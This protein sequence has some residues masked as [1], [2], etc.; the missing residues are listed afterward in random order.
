M[1]SSPRR[2]VGVPTDQPLLPYD[3]RKQ[4]ECAR[5][6]NHVPQGT[7]GVG[8]KP[9]TDPIG[10]ETVLIQHSAITARPTRVSRREAADSALGTL[11]RDLG[12]SRDRRNRTARIQWAP[13]PP[14]VRVAGAQPR[15]PWGLRL[16]VAARRRAGGGFRMAARHQRWIRARTRRD[17]QPRDALRGRL[18]DPARARLDA[19]ERGG[20]ARHEPS[21]PA[22]RKFGI[23]AVNSGTGNFVSGRRSSA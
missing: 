3:A 22:R 21:A 20:F 7:A 18:W 17:R 19:A 23:G 10:F 9:K 4:H 6:R 8:G 14:R 13:A 5:F 16:G 1:L 15:D 11:P 2:Y 12:R